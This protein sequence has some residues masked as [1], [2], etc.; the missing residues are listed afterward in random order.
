MPQPEG[1]T[2]GV[3]VSAG[4]IG[5]PGASELPTRSIDETAAAPADDHRAQSPQFQES[6]I[7]NPVATFAAMNPTTDQNPRPPQ[8]ETLEL[9]RPRYKPSL[10]ADVNVIER[11]GEMHQPPSKRLFDD[12]FARHFIQSR[13]GR[14]LEA[15][16]PVARIALPIYDRLYAGNHAHVI[17]RNRLYEQELRAALADGIDQVVLLGAGYDSTAFRLGLGGATLFDVDTPHTQSA[18]LSAAKRAGLG[19]I[20]QVTYVDCDFES[21]QPSDRLIKH[22]FDPSRRSLFVWLGVMYYL[23]E[24]SAKQTLREIATLTTPDSRLVVDYVDAAVIDGTTPHP[25]ARRSVRSL[26]RRREPLRFG[27]TPAAAESLLLEHGFAV[28][29]SL[30]VPDLAER[31]APPAGVWC[32]LDDWFGTLV[33]RRI[34]A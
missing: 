31:Y 6:E 11:A 1:R 10:T 4:R 34:Q 22:G 14:L 28:E 27:L 16:G 17:L 30:R 13:V 23:T 33:A 15:S 12:P 9:S 8:H 3:A 32:R 2:G 7:L 21:D 25:G 20:S 18:K 5:F 19:P 26:K 29:D 24:D